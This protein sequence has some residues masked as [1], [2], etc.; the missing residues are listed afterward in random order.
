MYILLDKYTYLFYNCYF[1]SVFNLLYSL[2]CS[3]NFN[4]KHDMLNEQT[5][6]KQAHTSNPSIGYHVYVNEL[7]YQIIVSYDV[8]YQVDQY[9]VHSKMC[10]V[11]FAYQLK[12]IILLRIGRVVRAL[13]SWPLAMGSIPVQARSIRHASGHCM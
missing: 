2:L 9:K 3:L 11:S 10:N 5:I 1:C 4:T 13:D 6:N 12:T 8:H 7:W